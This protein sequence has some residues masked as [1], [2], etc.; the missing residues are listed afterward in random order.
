MSTPVGQPELQIRSLIEAWTEALRAKDVAGRTAHYADDVLIFDVINP[1]Q[2]AGLDALK[3]RLA[4]WFSTFDG[5]IDCEVRDLQIT[6]D[7]HIAFCHSLQRFH[8]SLANG[9]MLD[10]LVRYT[11]CLRKAGDR[12]AVTHEHA[13][14]PF[15]P[16]TGL[17]SV[18][19]PPSTA[20]RP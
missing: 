16:A 13:S 7:Q 3:Q 8:G 5:P 20:E 19:T 10:M 1:V 9:G 14:T 12:W 4:Q 2:H 15:D 6:A 11:T 17:A 18:A